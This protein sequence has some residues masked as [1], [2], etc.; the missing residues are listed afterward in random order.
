MIMRKSDFLSGKFQPA[1]KEGACPECGGPM[2]E[3]DRR[4]ENQALFVWLN[5]NNNDCDGQWLRK[6]PS[7]ELKSLVSQ[8]HQG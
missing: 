8:R 1:E 4:N 3:V 7:R 2:T 5:C 6:I